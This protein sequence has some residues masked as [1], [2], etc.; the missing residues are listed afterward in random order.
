MG[1]SPDKFVLMDHYF[2]F[3]SSLHGAGHTYR[4]MCNSVILGKRL[5]LGR[6]SRLALCAAFIHDMARKHD[7]KCTMHGTWA[8]EEKMP[9]FRD[10][11]LSVGA[12]PD[13]IEEI[14]MAVTNHS[15]PEEL[16]SYHDYFVTTAILKDADALDRIRLGDNNL[17]VN[18]LRFGESR[19]LIPFSQELYY[20]TNGAID[21]D[22]DKALKISASLITV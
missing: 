10:L 16:P 14:R 18:F 8:A 22:F 1:I 2:D 9:I 12:M 17:K 15:L 20:R 7:G 4:V 19:E 21:L 5:K 3:K 13:E 6:E 11:F